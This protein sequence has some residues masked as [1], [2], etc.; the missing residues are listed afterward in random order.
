MRD[1]S[2]ISIRGAAPLRGAVALGPDP[3]IAQCVLVLAALCEGV[4]E[5]EAALLGEGPLGLLDALRALG[6]AATR[7]DAGVRIEGVGLHGL[8]MAPAALDCRSSATALALLSGALC[9]RPFGTRLTLA[10]SP[11]HRSLEHVVGALRARG[12]QIAES[13]HP[14]GVAIAPLL[15]DE[16]LLPIE[17]TLPEPDPNAKAALL[18]SALF[19]DAPTSVAEPLLS[20]DHIERLLMALDVPLRRLGSM[21]GLDPE[22]WSRRLPALGRVALPCDPDLAGFV[23]VAASVIPGSRVALRDVA[24]NPTRSGMLDALRLLGARILVVA[25]GDR[26]GREPV[27]E[28]QAQAARARGGAMGGEIAL[29]CGAGLPAL[30][31]LGACSAR[32]LSLADGEPFAPPGDEIW[33]RLAALARAF[34]A[35]SQPEPAGLT[36]APVARLRG[37]RIDAREDHRLAR[38]AVVFGLAAEGETLVENASCLSSADPGFLPALR[39]LGARIEVEDA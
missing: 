34:G 8:R 9:A 13:Q 18:L 24:V 29:R 28:V 33:E 30:C 4:T 21:S 26:A 15:P 17:C 37:A 1:S 16:G 7:D 12:A 14:A 2:R 5:I 35:E 20:P 27:A 6:V 32:G 11:A 31:L 38:T 23:A 25:K 10:P 36:V 3:E 22:Q 39:A 19:A